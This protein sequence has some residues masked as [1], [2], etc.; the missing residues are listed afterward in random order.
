M[1]KQ[2]THIQNKRFGEERALYMLENA[3]VENCSFAGEEDGESALKEC[4]HLSLKDSLFDLRYPLWHGRGLALEGCTLTRN[5][6]AALWYS[7]N[8]SIARS[9]LEGIKALRECRDAC[10]EDSGIVS[11]EFGWRCKNVALKNCS[12][13]SEYAFFESSA[14]SFDRLI[15]EGK[16]A[17]QYTK[18]VAM[19]G[20]IL[21]TKDAFWHAK[22]VIVEDSVLAG[23]Y[24]G[25]Y[26]DGLTLVRCTISGTQPLCYCKNLRLID[27][28]MEGCDLAFEYSDAEADI[29]GSILSVKN[30]RSG[31]ITADEIGEII[32]S[33]SK[34]ETKAKIEVRG[35]GGPA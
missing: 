29:S 1:Q 16:Y 20:S 6:R 7:R 27:C 3:A 9:K 11:P 5:C 4:K 31:R 15:F 24:L 25:W 32:L 13:T 34:Y 30:P 21:K 14:L 28:T 17:F 35:N 12:L 33:D 23:E 19:K 18:N 22:N 2:M 10:I 26:S 8:I